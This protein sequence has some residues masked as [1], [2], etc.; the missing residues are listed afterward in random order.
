MRCWGRL[1]DGYCGE[2]DLSKVQRARKRRVPG[3]RL[4]EVLV[5]KQNLPRWLFNLRIL[6]KNFAIASH[7]I[8]KHRPPPKKTNKGYGVIL[9]P[10]MRR[11]GILVRGKNNHF[12]VNGQHANRYPPEFW[13]AQPSDA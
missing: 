13:T 2:Y 3:Q 8:L 6:Q 1:Q 5:G 4:S 11:Q 12:Y 9:Q 7:P 10:A